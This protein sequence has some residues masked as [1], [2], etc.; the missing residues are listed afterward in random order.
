MNW[1]VSKPQSMTFVNFY[2]ITFTSSS[3]HQIMLSGTGCLNIRCGGLPNCYWPYLLRKFTK[4]SFGVLKLLV[5]A[6][7]RRWQTTPFVADLYSSFRSVL[8]SR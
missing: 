7:K 1:S 4:R 2:G 6:E 3:A 8:P 5:C